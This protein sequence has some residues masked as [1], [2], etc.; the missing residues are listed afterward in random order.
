MLQML[1]ISRILQVLRIFTDI[2]CI[3][4]LSFKFHIVKITLSSGFHPNFTQEVFLPTDKP[5]KSKKKLP[6][7]GGG[8]TS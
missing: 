5:K 4:L 1:R 6:T 2:D 8:S 7:S 3:I